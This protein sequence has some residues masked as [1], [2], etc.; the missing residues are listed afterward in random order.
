MTPFEQYLFSQPKFVSYISAYNSGLI[1]IERAAEWISSIRHKTI[2]NKRSNEKGFDSI[3]KNRK[4]KVET[5][6]VTVQFDK[7]SNNYCGNVSG[8]KSKDTSAILDVF[9]DCV[10]HGRLLNVVI[11]P[12]IWSAR[13]IGKDKS[14]LKFNFGKILG[15]NKKLVR[16]PWFISFIEE[17]SINE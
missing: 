11:P 5:K 7:S 3:S 1:T 4:V 16:D 10:D 17:L 15:H 2:L 13:R 12:E 14:Y 6:F 8:L 9:F